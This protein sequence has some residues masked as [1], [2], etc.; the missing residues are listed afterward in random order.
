MATVQDYIVL[1]NGVTLKKGQLLRVMYKNSKKNYLIGRV[2]AAY[3]YE[4]FNNKDDLIDVVNLDPGRGKVARHFSRVAQQFM[5]GTLEIEVLS[6]EAVYLEGFAGANGI[7][8]AL[9]KGEVLGI[10]AKKEKK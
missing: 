10:A 9:G 8:Y 1:P 3:I 5:E 4:N 6:D 7:F 2:M